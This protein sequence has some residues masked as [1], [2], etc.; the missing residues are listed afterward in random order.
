MSARNT[1]C[2]HLRFLSCKCGGTFYFFFFG[3]SYS[4]NCTAKTPAQMSQGTQVHSPA[5]PDETS[6]MEK[7][8][9]QHS[10]SNAGVPATKWCKVSAVPPPPPV[11]TCA[12]FEGHTGQEPKPFLKGGVNPRRRAYW[13]HPIFLSGSVTLLSAASRFSDSRGVT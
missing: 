3:R 13:C 4:V 2:T 11:G 7:K 5:P 12:S 9:Q 10:C 8:V 6:A 1:W